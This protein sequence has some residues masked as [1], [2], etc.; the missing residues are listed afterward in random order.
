MDG[1]VLVVDDE[2][3]IR[4]LLRA[5]LEEEGYEVATA[6]SG[7]EALDL[8]AVAAPALVLSDV[9]MPGM[10]GPEL[11]AALRRSGCAAPVVLMSASYRPDGAADAAC[12]YSGFL[13]KP[14]D[15]DELLRSVALHAGRALTAVAMGV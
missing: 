15:L 10:S 1:T 11:C 8:A 3:T 6:A 2:A 13:A 7:Q 4:D 5:F 12:G 9:L 14:F